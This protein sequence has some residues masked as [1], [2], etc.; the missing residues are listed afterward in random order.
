MPRW[1]GVVEQSIP[2][3]LCARFGV[4]SLRWMICAYAVACCPVDLV[5]NGFSVHSS[6]HI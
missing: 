3:A 5:D 4:C 6:A 1:L 2:D